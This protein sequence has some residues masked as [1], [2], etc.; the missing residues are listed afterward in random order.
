MQKVCQYV[1]KIEQ[2]NTLKAICTH[3]HTGLE[4]T[5]NITA[6]ASNPVSAG[7]SLTLQCVAVSDRAP[8]LQWIDSDGNSIQSGNGTI[9]SA[10]TT[11]GDTSTITLTFTTLR[12]SD[13]KNY[14][15]RCEIEVPPSTASTTYLVTVQSTLSLL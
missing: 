8:Q 15:C 9:V 1:N 11:S 6:S 14:T 2:Q 13:A 4:H 5:L 12:T 3:T 10:T 7:S